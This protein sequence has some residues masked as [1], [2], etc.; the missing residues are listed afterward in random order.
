MPG[1]LAP[2][3]P[4]PGRRWLQASAVGPETFRDMAVKGAFAQVIAAQLLGGTACASPR[5]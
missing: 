5:V 3:L 2:Y 1:D 4:V